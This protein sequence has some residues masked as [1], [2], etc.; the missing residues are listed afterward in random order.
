LRIF[1]SIEHYDL[2]IAKAAFTRG[3]STHTYLDEF[4]ADLF[5]SSHYKDVQKAMIFSRLLKRHPVLFLGIF[6]QLHQK[7]TQHHHQR[8]YAAA[9]HVHF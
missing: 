1:N 3:E 6:F 4:D 9:Y 2:N 7:T 8:Q 5:L